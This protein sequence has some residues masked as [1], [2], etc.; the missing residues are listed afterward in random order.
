MFKKIAEKF[1]KKNNNYA[2]LVNYN[3]NYQGFK[4]ISSAMEEHHERKVI[5]SRNQVKQLSDDFYYELYS[6][7]NL[8]IHYLLSITVVAPLVS[9]ASIYFLFVATRQDSYPIV[10]IIL[11]TIS[12][13]IFVVCREKKEKLILQKQSMIHDK[14]FTTIDDARLYWILN[15]V[16]MRTDIYEFAKKLSEWKGLKEK[17]NRNSQI[18]WLN[19]IYDPQSK[20]R[21]LALLIAFISLF[22]VVTMN[23]FEIEPF[24]VIVSFFGLKHILV[25]E[26]WLILFL[27][28]FI[29]FLS[30]QLIFI[31]HI[32]SRG[33]THLIG[34][35]NRDNLSELKFNILIN[36]LLD[37]IDLKNED[38]FN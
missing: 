19:Y 23:T 3:F 35:L 30:W 24:S 31:G 36:F 16:G 2:P 10:S 1:R 9:I 21:I 25:E 5:I 32:L 17:Y 7:K 34:L 33:A 29:C 6:F 15:K 20:P 12:L 13:I 37:N 28:F 22:T 11:A 26:T 27:I 14:S 18:N 38:S 4:L 8:P